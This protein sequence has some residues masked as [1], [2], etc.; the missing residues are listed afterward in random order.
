MG[1]KLSSDAQIMNLNGK[2]GVS[3]SSQV[4]RV[5]TGMLQEMK[6]MQTVRVA[7]K[8][9]TLIATIFDLVQLDLR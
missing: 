7:P 2:Y 1:N 5:S 8:T 9:P 4:F 3:K 6:T